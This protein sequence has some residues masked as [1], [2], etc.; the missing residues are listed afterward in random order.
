MTAV[1]ARSRFRKPL[2]GLA[3]VLRSEWCKLRSVRSTLWTATF[4]VA[5]N[6]IV[7]ALAAIF[8]PSHLSAHE[9]A[10]LDSIRVSLAGL[11]LSQ[12]AFGVL[13]VLVISSEYGTGMIRATL[14]AVPRRRMLLTAKTLVLAASAL[15][16]GTLACLAAYFV[17]QASLSGDSLR[18]H[19]SDP[20]VFRALLGGGLYLTVLGLLGLGLGAILRSSAG[21]IAT[22]FGV[23]FIPTILVGILPAT[24]QNRIAGYLPMNAGDAIYSLHRETGSLAPWAGFAVFCGYAALALGLGLVLITR[25]DA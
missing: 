6:V 3:D 5:A 20:G 22:L 14:A 7:A 9:K 2:P 23:L 10:T 25:R 21:A 24:W 15:V 19:I 18:T 4:A 12:I 16:V 11:H 1:A 17:F 8:L 13:G